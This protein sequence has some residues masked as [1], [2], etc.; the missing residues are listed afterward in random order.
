M[1]L[2]GIFEA[3]LIII[4]EFEL[5]K[6][7]SWKEIEYKAFCLILIN[8]KFETESGR[9][10]RFNWNINDD[11]LYYIEDN[12]YLGYHVEDFT[13]RLKFLYLKPLPLPKN[14]KGEKCSM[15][16]SQRYY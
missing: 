2:M 3:S 16:Y 11:I 15:S 5:G 7:F 6:V 1:V 10:A 4:N 12:S 14:F 8:S 9:S 13:S